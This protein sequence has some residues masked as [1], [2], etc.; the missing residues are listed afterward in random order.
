[1]MS[2]GKYSLHKGKIG[3]IMRNF[4]MKFSEALAFYWQDKRLMKKNK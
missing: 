3:L 4:D 1:M 2:K